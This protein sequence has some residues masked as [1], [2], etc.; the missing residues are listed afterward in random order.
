MK[1]F[2]SIPLACHAWANGTHVAGKSSNLFFEDD[3]I[4]SYGRHYVL[5]VKGDGVTFV[6]SN[7]RSNSTT[8]QKNHVVR[9]L[10]GEVLHLPFDGNT[11]SDSSYKL[12]NVLAALVKE[13]EVLVSKQNKA[14][15]RSFAYYLQDVAARTTRFCEIFNLECP[16]IEGYDEAIQTANLL[17]AQRDETVKKAT[18]LQNEKECSLLG[19]WLDGEYNGTLYTLSS[20]YLRVKGNMLQ[21]SHGAE[22]NVITAQMM[23]GMLCKGLLYVGDKFDGFTVKEIS[24]FTVTIGCHKFDRVILDHFFANKF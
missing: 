4:Y 5:A 2:S 19:K 9:A 14:K 11:W 24:E 22:I 13:C 16:K 7:K 17:S 20:I 18:V 10:A 8:E 1:N 23:Y 6:N 3:E 12:R 21:T 15:S